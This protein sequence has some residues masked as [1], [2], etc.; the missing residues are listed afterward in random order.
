MHELSIATSIVESVLEFVERH[1]IKQVVEVRLLLG[2]LMG[3]EQEQLRFCYSAITKET[4]IENSTLEF[5]WIGA[6][7]HC[8]HCDYCGQPKYWDDALS[9]MPV[10][11]L[12]C[13]ECG[14]AVDAT[15]GTECAIKAIRYVA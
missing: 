7:V 8:P 14:K 6:S 13:P 11:T 5:D 1:G 3:V 4:A 9:F 2:E 15:R 12:Q 10:I